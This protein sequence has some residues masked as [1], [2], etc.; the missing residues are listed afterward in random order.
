MR[1]S[2][3]KKDAVFE[4]RYA[5]RFFCRNHFLSMYWKR[6]KRHIA[7]TELVTSGDK[8]GIAVSGGKDS[9]VL[10]HIFHELFAKRPD[11]RLVAITI[12]EGIHGYRP[13]GVKVARANC[14]KL[15]IPQTIVSFQETFD[16]TL[17]KIVKKGEWALTKLTSKPNSHKNLQERTPCSYCGVLRRYLMNKVAKELGC[18]KLA[19]GHNLD[20]EAQVILMNLFRGDNQKLARLGAK[21]G[22]KSFEGFVQRIKPLRVVPEK[23]NAL[24][25]M[26]SGIEVDYHVCPY[27]HLAYREEVRALLDSIEQNHPGTKFTL[28]GSMDKIISSL[29]KNASA[30]GPGVC[31]SCGELTSG[32]LCQTCA[33]L[34]MINHG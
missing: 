2:F 28:L 15:G 23:E 16:N 33:Y 14:E 29:K 7:K 17:D 24:F 12:D 18:T 6:V 5:G 27:A 13:Y 22:I 21:V 20:D 3:C 1:C 30:E 34:E 11:I 8:V 32:D 4:A 19:T 10:L 9:V 25:A 26:L 31:K